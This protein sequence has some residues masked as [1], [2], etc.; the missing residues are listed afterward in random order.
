MNAF[1]SKIEVR[2]HW[3]H[4][5]DNVQFSPQEIYA[6]VETVIREKEIPGV[7]TER[8]SYS[9]GNI[10]S[11]NR[12]YLRI[13]RG[14]ILFDVCAAPFAKGFFISSWQADGSDPAKGFFTSIPFIGKS[15]AQAFYQKTY[16]Q[17]DAEQMYVSAMHASL[18][19]VIDQVTQTQGV[20]SLT[21][22]ERMLTNQDNKM[23]SLA[24]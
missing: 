4:F 18:M 2:N 20:R 10:F 17:L 16:F 8:V 24:L 3:Q 14:T 7:K 1:A 13:S 9:Q 15:I 19:E 11:A 6:A 12:E 5:F 21:A 22:P 23:L